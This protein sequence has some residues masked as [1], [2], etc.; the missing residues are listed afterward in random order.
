M[1]KEI[2]LYIAY[3]FNHEDQDTIMEIL[4]YLELYPN[5]GFSVLKEKSLIKWHYK[6]LWM[7]DLVQQIGQDIVRQESPNDPGECSRL[8][9]YKD[10]DNVLT[11]NTVRGY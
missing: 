9:L 5:I 8:W 3:F 6:Q 1:E 4:D 2:F 7:H 11:K 10:I